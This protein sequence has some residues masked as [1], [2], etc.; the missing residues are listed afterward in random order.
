MTEDERHERLTKVCARI[1]EISEKSA[2]RDGIFTEAEEVELRDLYQ[3]EGSLIKL[4]P[5][6]APR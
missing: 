1:T 4:I 2:S 5:D 6:R 3:E